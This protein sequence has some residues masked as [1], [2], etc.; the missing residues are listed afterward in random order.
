MAETTDDFVSSLKSLIKS[1]MID[2]NTSINGEI[3]SYSNG[4]ATVRPTANKAFLDGE[5]LPF[6]MIYKCP[7]RWPSFN[8]GQCGFKGPIK[9]G[10]Q[11]LVVFAQQATDGTDDLRKFDLNDAYCLPAH[12]AMAGQGANNDDTI[13]YFGP[14]YIKF[15]ASGAMEINAPGGCKTIAP[16][17]LFTGKVTV[18]GLVTFL[19]GMVGST[20][21]GAAFVLNGAVQFIGSLTSN[22]KNISDTHTHSDP[23]GG[24]TG[25]VN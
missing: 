11:V 6:P 9:P 16:T 25:P 13:M 23:Q 1:E 2:V 15:D 8:G 7:V 24:S 18:Q 17:N 10:D 4:F 22:G 21:S 12:N 19:A 3:V 14:A 5:S 20:L